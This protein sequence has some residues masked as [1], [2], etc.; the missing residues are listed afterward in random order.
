MYS[1]Y[2]YQISFTNPNAVFCMNYNVL[3]VQHS[4]SVQEIQRRVFCPNRKLMVFLAFSDQKNQQDF[5]FRGLGLTHVKPKQLVI[6]IFIT[7]RG[8]LLE[9]Y[10]KKNEKERKNVQFYHYY[11]VAKVSF[12]DNYLMNTGTLQASG[13]TLYTTTMI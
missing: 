1:L 7:R 8:P 9:L 12:S 5:A 10:V 6:N 2:K 13:S 11:T 3:A 4:I